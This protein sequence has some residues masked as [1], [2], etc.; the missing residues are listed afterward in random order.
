MFEDKLLKRYYTLSID[1]GE[2]KNE[3]NTDFE[4]VT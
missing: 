1:Q 2:E 3:E 4:W